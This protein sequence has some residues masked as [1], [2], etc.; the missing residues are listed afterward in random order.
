MTATDTV[1][2]FAPGPTCLRRPLG[3]AAGG[4]LL[5]QLSHLVIAQLVDTP[6]AHHGAAGRIL[7]VI[8]LAGTAVLLVAVLRNRPRAATYLTVAGAAVAGAA[9]VLHVVPLPPVVTNPY[10]GG[11]GALAW[12][13]VVAV[14]AAGAGAVLVGRHHRPV[15][16]T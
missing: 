14:I 3:L 12:A 15:G 16:A 8:G 1:N 7:H 13:G 4:L 5:A 6:Q 2:R 9:I 10:W 11:A